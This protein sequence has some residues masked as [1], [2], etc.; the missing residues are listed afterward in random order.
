[1]QGFTASP[2][3]QQELHLNK[4]C[5]STRTAPQQC[6]AERLNAGHRNRPL[7]LL[8]RHPIFQFHQLLLPNL[9]PEFLHLRPAGREESAQH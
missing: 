1:M 4:N 6:L 5:T 8:R 9:A 7:A 3:P 2:T